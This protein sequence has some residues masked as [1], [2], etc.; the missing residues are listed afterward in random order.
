MFQDE[1]DK[2]LD[3]KTGEIHDFP[4]MEAFLS[5]AETTEDRALSGWRLWD[6]SWSPDN[7]QIAFSAYLNRAG[8]YGYKEWHIYVLDLQS[9]E[10]YLLMVEQ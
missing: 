4:S 9:G 7:H 10:P 5:Q 1:N 6:V 2:I 3:T 8:E